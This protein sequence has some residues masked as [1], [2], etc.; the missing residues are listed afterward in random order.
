LKIKDGAA[1]IAANMKIDP[2]F[3]LARDEPA[4]SAGK[5]LKW[6]VGLRT[7]SKKVGP[8][9]FRLNRGGAGTAYR[10]AANMLSGYR[11]PAKKRL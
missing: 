5:R 3:H 4:W 6:L 8:K 7:P 11:T 2:K 10:N 1:N 9:S